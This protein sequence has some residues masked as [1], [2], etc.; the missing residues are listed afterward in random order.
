MPVRTR[1]WGKG[2]FITWNTRVVWNKGCKGYLSCLNS[3]NSDLSVVPMFVLIVYISRT[4]ELDS[5]V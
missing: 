1:S 4:D 3:H 5:S 2:T